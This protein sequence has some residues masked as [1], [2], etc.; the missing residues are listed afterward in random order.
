MGQIFWSKPKLKYFGREGVLHTFIMLR[1]DKKLVAAKCTGRRCNQI[2]SRQDTDEH[3]V[4]VLPIPLNRVVGHII[5]IQ[6]CVEL[7]SITLQYL[8]SPLLHVD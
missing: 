6:Y 1:I 2:D 5:V 7:F 8:P 4:D 3:R